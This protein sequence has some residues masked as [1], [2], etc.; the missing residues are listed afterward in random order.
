MKHINLHSEEV[1]ISFDENVSKNYKI[2][3][4]GQ[5]IH[6]LKHLYRYEEFTTPK[7]IMANILVHA[8]KGVACKEDHLSIS[9]RISLYEYLKD[10]EDIEDPYVKQFIEKSKRLLRK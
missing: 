1:V 10:K 4:R 5:I 7:D 6:C 2:S 9:E 3:L 8:L